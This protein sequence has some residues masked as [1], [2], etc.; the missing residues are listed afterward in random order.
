MFIYLSKKIAIPNN[1]RLNCI[2][3]NKDQGYVAVGGEDGLLKVLKLEQ[4]SSSNVSAQPGKALQASNLSMNQTLE[5][6]KSSIQVVTWNESQ[7]KLTSSDKD[8]VIMVWML[9]KGSWYEEM[10]ND[11]K[12]STVKGMAWTGDGQKI[13]IVY[14]DGTVIVGSVDGNRIWGKDLK[15]VSLAGVQWS[16]DGRLLLFSIKNGEV[17]LYDNQGVFVMKLHIQC[18]YLTPTKS[19]TVVGLCWYHRPVSANRPVLAICYENGRMQLMRNENDDS[20]VV[21]DT[22]LQA[23]SCMWNHDGTILAICGMKTNLTSDKDSS[24]VLFYSPYGVH[25]RT[26]KIPGKE[27]T[28]LSWEGK[29]LRIALSVDSFIYF[30]NIRPDYRWCYFNRTV[31]YQEASNGDE[32]D[33]V[34]F[35][36]TNSN[37]CYSKQID[38]IMSMAATNDHCVIA[39]E[40]KMTGKEFS[41]VSEGKGK[42]LMYQLLICN[43][44]STTVDSKYLDIRPEF[45]TMNSSHVIV[46]S[47]DHFL[48]WHYHTPKGASTLHANLKVKRDRKYHI[49][50]TPALEVLN[51]L[52]SKTAQEIP[53]KVDPSQD[54]ICCIASSE[55]LLLIGRESGLIHEYTLP[56]LVLRNRHYLQNRSYKL[57]I[58]CNSTRAAM[59]DCNGVLTTLT[60]RDDTSELDVGGTAGMVGQEGAHIE[61][62]DVWAIC[63]AKDNP[64]L[65]AIMEKTRMYILRGADPEEPITCSG[66]IGNFEDLEITGVLLDDIIKGGATPNVKE[67]IL[68]LRVKSLRDTEDLLAHVGISEAKQFIEDNA[69]PRLWRLLAEASLKKLDLETAESAFVRCSNYP[70]IQMIKRLKTIQLESLQRAEIAAFFGEFDEAEKLYLDVDR[71]DCA[72]RLRQTLC[73]WFRTV[74]L[75]RLGPGISDQQMENAWREIGHHYMNMRVCDSAKEYY[76]KAHHIEGLMDALYNLEQYD[77]LVGCMHKLPEKSQQ[78]AKLGQMLATVGMCEQSV[79][80]YLKLGDVKSAVS[81]CIAL[82]QWG[83]A[84][85]LAQK[86]KMPQIN[87]LLSKHAA[88]LL[89]EGK[90]PEAIELQRKA[91]RYLDAARLLVK[92]AEAEAEKKSDYIRIKQLYVLSGLLGEEYIEKQMAILAGGSRAAVLSQLNPEDAVLIEQIW[93]HAEAYHYMLLAQRQLRSGLLHSAVITTLRLREYEDVL[94]VEVLYALLALASCADR[95]FGTCSKAFIKLE[96]IETISETRRQQY[97]ELAINIF[98]RYE[99]KDNKVKHISCYTCETPVADCCTRCPNCGS[100]FPPCIASGQPLTNPTGAWQC[101]GCYHVANPLEI[102][103]RK[104]CPL[105]HRLLAT[106]K[107]AIQ[108]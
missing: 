37:Q 85:E 93:H 54:P 49:D 51:D 104:T 79:A 91:G 63:W 9:Y 48:L 78:L 88:Q 41:I 16:P 70:G 94:D 8:G 101:S 89:Q 10:T 6:H 39:V 52:D 24:Q 64:Q 12:K 81:T 100:R 30:A 68:Q 45:I 17:H 76:E 72:I 57:A 15:N 56:H 42:D 3:W 43:S 21:V 71:R 61:R 75:Y 40:T 33:S 74:H 97:E 29:S 82:R 73:D 87:T 20:P 38:A 67:H 65:L 5:G 98:T 11:R 2:A 62:K 36:D 103:S 69:H 80:A 34:T 55:S 4:A 77:E 26:L 50:D 32:Q 35:W 106:P 83:L 96:S 25:I 53:S 95:S 44:I 99:P 90:L 27:I 1:T 105:C 59:I 23:I 58:N 102:T 92:M 22:G 107:G 18:V 66:Y 7:Q 47:K 46:A 13:C 86:Y 108:I 14:E 28:S 31:C 60:L 84:V 19:I